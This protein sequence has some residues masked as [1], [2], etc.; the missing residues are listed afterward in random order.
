MVDIAQEKQLENKER[1]ARFNDG[2]LRWSL[3]DF[4]A[5]EEMVRVLEYGSE[6]YDDHNWKKGMPITEVYESMQRHLVAFLA[7]EDLDPESGLPHT[8]HILCNALFLNYM[9]KYHKEKHDNRYIDKNKE[10]K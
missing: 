8:G 3:V 1:G 10:T 6:K 7:G 9:W 5:L 2:K 4:D